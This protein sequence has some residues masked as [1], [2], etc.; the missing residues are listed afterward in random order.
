MRD[1][2][3]KII[4]EGASLINGESIVV[5]ATWGTRNPKTGDMVQ[6]WILP[7]DTPPVD[8][9]KT[10]ADEAV[11][12]DCKHRPVNGNSC[13]VNVFHAPRAVYARYQR[14][15]YERVALN[16]AGMRRLTE[17]KTVRIGSYGDPAAV[18]VKVWR[19]LLKHA[20]GHT[21]YTHQ[22]R[23]SDRNT[24]A[25]KAFTMASV[26]SVAE[27]MDAQMAGWRTFR[28]RR[29][30]ENVLRGEIMCPASEEAGKRR[31]CSTCTAC[32]G[33]GEVASR[34]FRG[35]AIVAHGARASN[36][37]KQAA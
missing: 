36:Y 17:N 23:R 8:A 9:V 4:Y 34:G 21:S 27:Q 11:C 33:V 16:S 6:T 24:Q 14:G 28:V 20:A 26:D 35:V 13:Y 7:A 31:T 1:Q 19:S 22:W 12:G 3:G 15:G 30:D 29:E 5:V 10:G 37:I 2:G 18:P 25:L 32:R